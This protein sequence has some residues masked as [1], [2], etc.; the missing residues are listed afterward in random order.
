MNGRGTL[1]EFA[2]ATPSGRPYN[3]MLDETLSDPYSIEIRAGGGLGDVA[4]VALRMLDPGRT[5]FFDI[6]AHIGTISI[7]MAAEGAEVYAFELLPDNVPALETAKTSGQ[8]SNLHI[9]EAAIAEHSGSVAFDGAGPFARVMADG[10]GS[11]TAIAI[12]D[13]VKAKDIRRVDL[14]KLDIEGSEFSAL[15]GMASLLDR[16]APTIIIESNVWTCGLAGYCYREPLMF[17]EHRGY[18]IMRL[19]RGALIKPEQSLFQEVLCCDY[20]ATKK[21]DPAE[22]CDKYGLKF[23]P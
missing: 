3:L 12:D 11:A 21:L 15:K 18:R 9:V 8:Y 13:Y 19:F 22:F 7:P 23:L 10:T 14:I 5:V 1:R 16:D 2:F 17:L 6:G 20:V 4:M